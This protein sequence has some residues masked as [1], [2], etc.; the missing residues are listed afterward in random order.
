MVGSGGTLSEATRS[1]P[2]IETKLTPP[3][4]RSTLIG[5]TQLNKRL[6][7]VLEKPPCFVL[8]SAPPGYGKTATI[9]EWLRRGTAPSTWLTLDRGDNDPARF[10]VYLTTALERLS[11]RIGR[12]TKSLIGSSQSSSP[13]FLGSLLIEDISYIDKHFTLI[14]DDYHTIRNH[15]VHGVIQF[16]LDN[17]PPMLNHVILTREDPPLSLARLKSQNRMIELRAQDLRFTQEETK[18]FFRDTME[19]DVEDNLIESLDRRVEGWAAG[20]QLAALSLQSHEPENRKVIVDEFD[21]SSRYLV[22]Y[23]AEEVLKHQTKDR[24]EFLIK[25]G[26]LDRFCPGLCNR[27]LAR[28]D[29]QRILRE[30]EDNNYFLLPLDEKRTWYRYHPLFADFLT[31]QLD[32]N[33]ASELYKKAAQWLEENNLVVEMVKYAIRSRDEEE[34]IQYIV[35]AAPWALNR[36]QYVMFLSWVRS[37]QENAILRNIELCVYRAWAMFLTGQLEIAEESISEIK[38][39]SPGM[40]AEKN[41]GRCL[42]L[43]MWL[44]YRRG[45]QINP[46]DARRAFRSLGENDFFISVFTTMALGIALYGEG[47]ISESREM[48]RKAYHHSRKLE[49]LPLA[50][51]A[52]H[53][54]AFILLEQ[55]RRREAES[56][57]LREMEILET[58]FAGEP[59]IIAIVLILMASVCYLRDEIERAEQFARKAMEFTRQFDLNYL[60]FESAERI[61]AM[62][63]HAHGSTEEA[64]SIIRNYKK[65]RRDFSSQLSVRRMDILEVDISLMQGNVGFAETWAAARGLPSSY[66]LALWYVDEHITCARMLLRQHKHEAAEVLLEDLDKLTEQIQRYGTLITVR[67]LRA[68]LLRQNDRLER[69]LRIMERAISLAEEEDYKRPFMN[70]GP[71]VFSL[72]SALRNVSPRFI[73]ELL[74]RHR[75]QLRTERKSLAESARYSNLNT[76]DMLSRREREVL[77]CVAEGLSNTEIA[78]RLY[79]SVG[80]VKW[81]VNNIFS[82]LDVKSRTQAIIRARDVELL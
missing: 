33:Q 55:G 20:I 82:K 19:M 9:V 14:L 5:R 51:C 31:T 6:N 54:M 78:D 65:E 52:L 58:N 37:L 64:L 39:L 41:E 67:I 26:L 62:A 56:L 10:L 61:L 22:D 3:R 81:H 17:Q 43:K 76:Y 63:M 68:V 11:K 74:N 38:A 47:G 35:R 15:F 46:D 1:V 69:A 40:M 32:E 2:L 77:K 24:R 60:L 66:K 21:G 80:T 13:E 28:S 73:N 75:M 48:F 71:I 7:E 45:E 23:F 4:Y 79:I 25:T 57:C 29:S 36:G 42:S 16:L 30:M 44:S 18:D 8:V 49:N 59:P 27:L 70:E 50:L 53:N 12:S 72:L 34:M